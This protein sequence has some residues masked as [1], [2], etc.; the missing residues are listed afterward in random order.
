MTRRGLSVLVALL[1]GLPFVSY[2]W[3]FKDGPH[4]GFTA[5]GDVHDIEPAIGWQVIY[6]FD[7]NFALELRFTR[8]TDTLSGNVGERDLPPN[9]SMDMDLYSLPL[10]LKAGLRPIERWYIYGAGG[11]GFYMIKTDSANINY[12]TMANGAQITE[13]ELATKNNIGYH[14]AVGSEFRITE[15]W[16][17]FMEARLVFLQFSA[18]V[19]YLE[20]GHN[21]Y[22]QSKI[23]QNNKMDYNH[24]LF[25]MGVNYRF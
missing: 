3:F 13:A 2:G 25:T 22:H 15:N 8:Q 18:D 12:P 16:D 10:S 17:I 7:E 19:E 21:P 24:G 14:L 1:V 11:A 20:V 9:V 6:E 23:V 5:G 4:V